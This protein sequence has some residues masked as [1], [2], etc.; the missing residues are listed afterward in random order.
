MQKLLKFGILLCVLLTLSACGTKEIN[1]LGSSFGAKDDNDPLKL[2]ANPTFPAKQ[3]TPTLIEGRNLVPQTNVVPLPRPILGSSGDSPL[4]SDFMS[5]L[6]P[7]GAALTVWALAQGNWIWGYTLLDSKSFG[8][9][10]VWQL[11][12]R[13]DNIVLIKNAKT[14]TCLNAYKNGIVHFSCDAS[15]PAQL[16]KLKPMDNGAVQIENVGTK[17]CIQAPI[18]NPLGDFKVFSI[19]I[20]ECQNKQNL[21]Q[22]WY[23]TTPPFKAQP[24]YR[25]K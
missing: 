15:N 10:R 24:L 8:D 3:K 16:W 17:K 4:A 11:L 14:L 19:F 20:S 21:D 12:I 25:E 5:I 1:P 22:Q 2:G 6:G 23:L 18:D 9:A 7:S 13:P